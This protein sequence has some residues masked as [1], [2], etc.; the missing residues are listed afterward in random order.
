MKTK[1]IFL[2]ILVVLFVFIAI[3]VPA[4]AD[5]P[6]DKDLPPVGEMVFETS[7]KTYHRG[8]RIEV[9]VSLQN[10]TDEILDRYGEKCH[11]VSC[12]VFLP[13]NRLLNTDVM[14]RYGIKPGKYFLTIGRV[15]PIKNLEIL[16]DAFKQHDYGEFQLVIGGN[17]DTEYGQS[18]VK[19]AS[20]CKNVIF[21]GMVSGDTKEALL[22]NCLAYCLVS[23]SEGLPIALLEGMSYGNIPIVT[24]I[25]A[26][27]EVLEK[28]HVGLWSDV[29]NVEQVSQNMKTVEMNYEKL[30]SHCN[31]A[32]DIVK[33]NYTWSQIADKYIK[34]GKE[35]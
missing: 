5:G 35:L 17:T 7:T 20:G 11:V 34:L 26:I 1:K 3:M 31:S 23:S 24:R 27:Q 19:R 32:L 25:P 10:V 15:D 28:H 14:K 16:I 6:A 13:E 12:G 30:K 22:K 18:I 33:E 21:V 9:T 29:K 8:D 2:S 4:S